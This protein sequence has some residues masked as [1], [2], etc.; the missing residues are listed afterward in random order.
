MPEWRK[1]YI[2]TN[3][4][5]KGDIQNYTN[6]RLIKFMS[7][8]IKFW[9]KVIEHR[10]RKMIIIS[11][12]QVDFIFERFIMDVIFLIRHLIKRY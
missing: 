3:L 12:N 8:I 5:D 7:H 10:L 2:S 6:Y 4:Q 9:E 11:K 1:K